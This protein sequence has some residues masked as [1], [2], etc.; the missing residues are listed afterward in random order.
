MEASDCA[1]KV[2]ALTISILLHG[3]LSIIIT[4]GFIAFIG[5]SIE[6]AEK[7]QAETITELSV[8]QVEIE[9]KGSQDV[10]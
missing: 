4:A 10:G 7:G 5:W 8:C 9:K 2:Y 1:A 3:A 6:Q